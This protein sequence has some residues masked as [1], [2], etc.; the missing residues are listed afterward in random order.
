VK[1]DVTNEQIV[2]SILQQR[3]KLSIR[4]VEVA[5]TAAWQDLPLNERKSYLR[6]AEKAV[7]EEAKER[8]PS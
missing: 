2:S 8:K 5:K 3:L 6:H 4:A 1:G 7:L